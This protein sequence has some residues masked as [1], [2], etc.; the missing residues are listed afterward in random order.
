M[1][2]EAVEQTRRF[3]D[4]FNARDVVRNAVRAQA[5]ARAALADSAASSDASAR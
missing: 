1:S 4:A 2:S 5:G 3:L